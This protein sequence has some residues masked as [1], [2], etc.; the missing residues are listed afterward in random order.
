MHII[1]HHTIPELSDACKE[2]DPVN[3]S[4]NVPR[5]SLGGFE[6]TAGKH[7]S[8]T[9]VSKGSNQDGEP[10]CGIWGVGGDGRH[11]HMTLHM[12]TT[13]KK[14]E[15]DTGGSCFESESILG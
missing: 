11:S 7:I 5:E 13:S 3:G 8:R 9:N 4:R 2:Y 15:N 6:D 1:P 14:K 10:G 12:L